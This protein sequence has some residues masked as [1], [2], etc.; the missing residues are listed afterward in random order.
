M[1]R[2]CHVRI[3]GGLGGKLPGATRQLPDRQWILRCR[4]DGPTVKHQRIAPVLT[5]VRNDQSVAHERVRLSPFLSRDHAASVNP[6]M[7]LVSL[8]A[9]QLSAPT[10]TGSAVSPE[11]SVPGL[12]QVPR[13]SGASNSVHPSQTVN[14]GIKDGADGGTHRPKPSHSS[15]SGPLHTDT[16]SVLCVSAAMPYRLYTHDGWGRVPVA[17]FATLQEARSAFLSLGQDPWYRN[18]GSMKG[19][20]H[21]NCGQ[22]AEERRL[23]WLAFS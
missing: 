19:I 22:A 14:D 20:E 11:P 10:S 9:D 13:Q 17:E 18:D 5:V 8:A 7:V 6:A 16:L 21:V 15:R 1:T 2:E 3:C 23:E 4:I 12:K